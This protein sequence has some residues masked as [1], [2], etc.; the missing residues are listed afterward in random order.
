MRGRHADAIADAMPAFSTRLVTAP[1]SRLQ[2]AWC[3]DARRSAGLA[4]P[5]CVKHVVD[6]VGTARAAVRACHEDPSDP[7]LGLAF[8]DADGEYRSVLTVGQVGIDGPDEIDSSGYL[9]DNLSK[10]RAAISTAY[11][12]SCVELGQAFAVG[13]ENREAVFPSRFCYR[14][15]HGFCVHWVVRRDACRLSA[16][17]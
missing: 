9:I 5:R 14:K 1:R 7:L 12:L 15:C 11:G 4:G 13:N 17:G 10:A 8:G 3:R 6:V 16:G 2:R